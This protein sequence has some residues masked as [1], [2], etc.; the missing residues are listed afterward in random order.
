MLR[1]NLILIALI[2]AFPKLY[3][4]VLSSSQS[5]ST[6][7][8]SNLPAAKSSWTNPT[9]A[10]VADNSFTTTDVQN[11][12]HSDMLLATNWGFSVGNGPNQIPSSA[13]I[14]GFEVEIKMKG[15]NNSIRDYIIQL[16]KNN[17][18]SS[19]NL[20]R[21]NSAWPQVLS[22]VKFGSSTDDWGLAW[23]PA[24]IAAS[25]FGVEIA[26]QGR[27]NPGTAMI[28]HIKITVYFN[29]RYYY[30]KSAGNLTTLGTW[31]V[32]TDGSGT[33]PP[34]FSDSGQIFFYRNRTTSTLDANLTISGEA[35]KMVIGD[36]TNASTLIIPSTA[37]LNSLV[38]VK[39]NGTLNISN[40]VSPTLGTL[41]DNSTVAY[42]ATANQTVQELTY[43]HIIFGGSG[44]KST[45]ITG[46]AI[47]VN[48][49]LTINSG[50]TFNNNDQDLVANGNVLNSGTTTGSSYIWMNGIAAS[51]ISGTNGTFSNLKTDNDFSVTLS[52]AQTIV[53]TL[54]LTSQPF[55]TG[56]FLKLNT[57]AIIVRDEG[58]LSASPMSN[59]L[60][61]IQYIGVS[62]TSGPELSSMFLRNF[63][64]S[65]IDT[66]PYTVTLNQ[67]LS[68][69]GYLKIDSGT[70]D[71]S[72]SNYNVTVL[73]DVT[74][75]GTLNNRSNTFTL[76]GTALQ[77][78]SG[79]AAISFYKL[80][81]NNTSASGVQLSTP[82][83]V[84]N[85]LNFANGI[86]TTDYIN[87]LTL[88]SAATTIGS[89][90]NK[91]VNGPLSKTLATTT[92]TSFVYPIGGSSLYRPVT[93][94]ITQSSSTATTYTVGMVNNAPPAAT[95]SSP[96]TSV[97]AYRYYKLSKGAGANITTAF[98]TL[99]YGPE[100]NIISASTT[101][102]AERSGSNWINLGGT[103]NTTP[104]GSI[105]STVN[106][107]SLN[108]FTIA[109]VTAALPI[110]LV[111]FK[112]II[113][114]GIAKLQWITSN[115]NNILNYEIEK[116]VTG[117]NWTTA[118]TTEPVSISQL[119]NTYSFTDKDPYS[120]KS[121]YRLK[122]IDK[123]L[124]FKYSDVISLYNSNPEKPKITIRPSLTDMK[125]SSIVIKGIVFSQN[126]KILLKVFN[127]NGALVIKKLCTAQEQLPLDLHNLSGGMYVVA[128]EIKGIKYSLPFI[129]W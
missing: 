83:Q 6:V 52:S 78:I 80:S 71:V 122:I 33:P 7:I 4:Q 73:K 20:A 109:D 100:D 108:E 26:A 13:V 44:I 50:I 39:P 28:D 76:N 45:D 34:N 113:S 15:S 85:I 24:E 120:G 90:N 95:L 46:N 119:Q 1:K 93:L 23:T 106:F 115:E 32:N 12:R 74:I 103:A 69:N 55:T 91:Y 18:I 51:T 104:S 111:S 42:N 25:T 121:Y 129:I 27:T 72:T 126:E 97:S 98:I 87:T 65:L 48:G 5:S 102:I 54:S 43:Y 118:G 3:A 21:T 89:T 56:A 10:S 96:L 77:T 114:N 22:Y 128:T 63:K 9:N 19:N 107:T 92:N 82:V 68:L 40:I 57:G 86:I 110:S 41:D 47:T 66:L 16:R 99:N 11:K 70:L 30:S 38:D 53:D 60:Y 36:G 94:E 35:S 14:N 67:A 112:G 31:G 59:N 29:L 105:R 101:R 84:N 88:G 124:S 61:D 37:V 2:I 117:N 116:N 64:L 125:Q 62:K 58:T 8:N 75:N 79:A 123:N 17:S 81:I 127:S 49:T